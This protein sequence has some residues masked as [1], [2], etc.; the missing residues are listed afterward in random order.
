MA[1]A[2][3]AGLDQGGVH[4]H[5]PRVTLELSLA[6]LSFGLLAALFTHGGG[7]RSR[8]GQNEISKLSRQQATAGPTTGLNRLRTEEGAATCCRGSRAWS[9]ETWGG[10]AAVVLTQST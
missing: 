8:A 7:A 9:W 3:G 5:A 1:G 4:P 2:A 6:S 10:D